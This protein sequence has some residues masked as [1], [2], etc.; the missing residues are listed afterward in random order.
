V[1]GRDEKEEEAYIFGVALVDVEIDTWITGFVGPRKG[2]SFR[3]NV[4]RSGDIEVGA[5]D[6]KLSHY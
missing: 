1:K 3:N 5:H 6:E 2:D 4:A